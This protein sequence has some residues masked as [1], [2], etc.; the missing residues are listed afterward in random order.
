MPLP[1][2]R[3][4][5]LRAPRAAPSV[6]ARG[7][8]WASGTAKSRPTG[9]LEHP[10]P[11]PKAIFIHRCAK[12][13]NA[14]NCAEDRGKADWPKANNAKTKKKSFRPN[15]IPARYSENTAPQTHPVPH[16]HR[17]PRP[18]YLIDGGYAYGSFP[19]EALAEALALRAT[20]L[21]GI[22]NRQNAKRGKPKPNGRK[23]RNRPSRMGVSMGD[24]PSFSSKEL[25]D[26][27]YAV[28]PHT[29]IRCSALYDASLRKR[30]KA[31]KYRS[32]PAG[33]TARIPH[34]RNNGRSIIDVRR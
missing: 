29:D 11:E 32:Q 1:A 14:T 6:A 10:A 8:V 13:T 18:N 30:K 21:H 4:V 23:S 19:N 28:S 5:S 20:S 12:S 2:I 26:G 9:G 7:S 33:L 16:H 15:R 31:G 34:M 22:G 25:E 24:M 17:P 3:E 27:G